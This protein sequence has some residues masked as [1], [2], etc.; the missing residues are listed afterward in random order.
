MSVRG[1]SG[2]GFDPIFIPK[3]YEQ[4]F[5]ELPKEIKNQISHR[6]LAWKQVRELI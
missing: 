1:E 5:A 6:F 2:F 4:T 3:G